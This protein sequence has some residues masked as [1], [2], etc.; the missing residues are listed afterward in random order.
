MTLSYCLSY[1][2]DLS[3]SHPLFLSLAS[4]AQEL[5]PS[6]LCVSRYSLGIPW[7]Q[8][9]SLFLQFQ[10]NTYTFA[11]PPSNYQLAPSYI[12]TPISPTSRRFLMS[13]LF[14]SVPVMLL[15]VPNTN[16]CPN[17]TPSI[18][19]DCCTKSYFLYPTQKGFFTLLVSG[20][21]FCLTL[22]QPSL[23]QINID[24]PDLSFFLF[25]FDGSGA[26]I[27]ALVFGK[28]ILHH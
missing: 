1:L 21:H 18:Y 5:I 26:Q 2:T 27:R 24:L 23:P 15:S 13:F 4:R 14:C 12:G 28:H 10:L 9:F 3:P 20:S 25:S 8:T 6:S 11:I 7:Q 19:L 16:F 17:T 22:W